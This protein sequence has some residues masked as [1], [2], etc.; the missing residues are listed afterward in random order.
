MKEIKIFFTNMEGINLKTFYPTKLLFDN[1]NVKQVQTKDEADVVMGGLI[2]NRHADY[3][4]KDKINIIISGENIYFRRNL[5]S[6]I[7]SIL[8]KFFGDKNFRRIN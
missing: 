1:F 5:L 4:N 8:G 3:L 7:E 2:K 6:A